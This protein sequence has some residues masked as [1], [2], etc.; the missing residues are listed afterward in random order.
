MSYS[1]LLDFTFKGIFIYYLR[2]KRK[3]IILGSII[4]IFTALAIWLVEDIS[5]NEVLV[6]LAMVNKNKTINV[7]VVPYFDPKDPQWNEIYQIAEEYPSTIKY[8]VINP[9]SGPCGNTLSDD[10]KNIISVLKSKK[11]ITLGYIFDSSESFSNI[12][13]YMKASTP[14]DGIFF[15]NEGSKD[16]LNKFGQFADY[17]HALGGMVYIN[18]GYNYPQVANYIKSGTVDVANI[19]ELEYDKSHHILV[20]EQ[21][22][23]EKLSVIL[24]NVTST[25]EMEEKLREI[26]SKGIGT[27]YIYGNSYNS[28]PTFFTEEIR[29]ASMTTIKN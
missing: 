24:G 23:A 1:T 11:I 22:P 4:G 10:W 25:S 28:L 6:S 7:I 9:C 26:A 20:N 14:T 12:D 8:V 16:N 27:I 17:V 21:L 5:V 29:Q 13:Y 19:H 15:D 2:L 18:P 3:I